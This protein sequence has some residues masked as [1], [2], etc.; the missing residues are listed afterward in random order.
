MRLL[1]I[2]TS[3]TAGSVVVCGAS[4]TLLAE[5]SATDVGTHSVWLMGAIDEALKKAKTTIDEIDYFAIGT[6]PGSFTGLRIGVSAIK[7]LAWTLKKPVIGLSVLEA[8]AMNKEAELTESEALICPILDARKNEVYGAL[9]KYEGNTLKRVT[10]DLAMST[11]KLLELVKENG[12]GKKIYFLGGGLKRYADEISSD[13]KETVEVDILPVE[14]W[15]LR[16]LNISKLALGFLDKDK[17]GTLAGKLYDASELLPVYL[18]KSE[19]ELRR[20]TS[21]GA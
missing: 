13:F 15:H 11:G 7:G 3:G 4:G 16:A 21:K 12:T 9:F 5:V 18:R 19:A 6:G 1:A 14:L 2:D 10:P 20:I 8:L 17:A